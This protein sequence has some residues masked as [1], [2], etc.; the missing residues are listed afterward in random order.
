[1]AE[2][3]KNGRTYVRPIEWST[4]CTKMTEP[5][6]MLDSDIIVTNIRLI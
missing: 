1:M 6:E 2:M 4:W 5:I 3:H